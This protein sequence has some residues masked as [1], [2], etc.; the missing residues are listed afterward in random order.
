MNIH[1]MAQPAPVQWSC[2]LL[3]LLTLKGW[4]AEFA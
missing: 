3:N 1:Q 2:S 4:K